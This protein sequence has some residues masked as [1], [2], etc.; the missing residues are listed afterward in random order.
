[1]QYQEHLDYSAE[2]LAEAFSRSRSKKLNGIFKNGKVFANMEIIYPDTK[3]VVAYEIAVLQFHNLVEFDETG[4]SVLT[5]MTGGKLIQSVV[6][7][8]NAHLQ[9]TFS[10]IPP[11]KLN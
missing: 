9:K 2:D 11:I 1:V 6:Q 8:A 4:Q 3:N 10:F 5:D 7:E